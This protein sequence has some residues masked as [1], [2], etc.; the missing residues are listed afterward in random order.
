MEIWITVK[1]KLRW[2]WAAVVATKEQSMR[3]HHLAAATKDSA[4]RADELRAQGDLQWEA[5]Q[6]LKAAQQ[7]V[8]DDNKETH[9]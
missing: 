6:G 1:I 3:D 4:Q 9:E 8:E 2:L 5:S 7:V